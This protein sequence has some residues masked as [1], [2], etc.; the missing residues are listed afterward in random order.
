[1]EVMA[2]RRCDTSHLVEVVGEQVEAQRE[3][4]EAQREQ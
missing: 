1:M 2:C 3:Q 4:V